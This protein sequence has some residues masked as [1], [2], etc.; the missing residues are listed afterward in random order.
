M[1]DSSDAALCRGTE[2]V[3]EREVVGEADG[4]GSVG[5]ERRVEIGRGLELGR[6]DSWAWQKE[7]G[8]EEL[9]G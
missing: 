1:R 6:K 5:S 3:K 9:S 8:E 2:K 4:W 7:E